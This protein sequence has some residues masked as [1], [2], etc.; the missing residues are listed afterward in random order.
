MCET[1]IPTQPSSEYWPHAP[2]HRLSESGVYFITAGTYGKKHYFAGATRLAVLCRGLLTVCSEA[3]WRIEAWCVFSNHYHF[4]AHSPPGGAESLAALLNRL[5]ARTAEWVNRLD[6][7]P[8]R[9]VWHNFWETKL[10]FE[11]SYLARLRYVH[12][13]AVRHGLVPVAVSYPYCSAAWLEGIAT[14]AQLRTLKSFRTDKLQ[15]HDDYEVS[16]DW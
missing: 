5:H 6:G 10:T 3:Q 13:N 1:T 7:T 2:M 8:Q 12:E 9:H 16:A 11:K 14:P 4:V 15:V